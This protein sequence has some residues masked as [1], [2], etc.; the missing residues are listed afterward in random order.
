MP[1]EDQRQAPATVPRLFDELF[2]APQCLGLQVGLTGGNVRQDAIR[3]AW[4]SIFF[5]L[6]G[7]QT[8]SAPENETHIVCCRGRMTGLKFL[9]ALTTPKCRMIDP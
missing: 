5:H 7:H 6:G 9:S 4:S 3:V 2:E 1:G 8:A